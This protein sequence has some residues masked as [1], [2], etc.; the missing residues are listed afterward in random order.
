MEILFFTAGFLAGAAGIYF[1]VKFKFESKAW[2]AE[3][4]NKIFEERNTAL[5]SELNIERARILELN[6]S[7]SA[8]EADCKNLQGRLCEQKEE[9]EN[10]QQKFSA[11]FKNIANELLEEKSRKFT[12]Q[13]KTNIESILNPLN[14]K[15]KEFQKRVED[16]YDKESKQRFSL[17]K[18]IK[19]LFDLNQ[20]MAKEANNLTVALKGQTKT[21]GSWGEFILDSILEKSGLQKGREYQ[22][23]ET[24]TNEDGRRRQPDVIINLPENKCLIID[25]KVSLFAYES[26]CSSDNENDKSLYLKDHIASIRKHIRELSSKNYQ[27]LYQINTLDF[28][29]LFMPIEPAFSLAV[30]N[31]LNIFNE[32]FERNIV[33]VSPSTLLA[34]LRTIA[35]IWRQEYQNRNAL[36]IARQSG[37]LYDKFQ[38]MI[39]DLIELGKKMRAM[40]INYDEAM[41]KLIS[42]RGNLVSS[43]EKIKKLGAKATKSL[44]QSLLERVDEDDEEE[45]PEG[46]LFR[47]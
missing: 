24:F 11:E 42:G 30:Q 12:E 45:N 47:R 43:V 3:E 32:A 13:N 5:S 23:Q 18:E 28:V 14:E 27:S 7:H 10:L 39:S 38:G 4:R 16:T 1:I 41:K 6:R 17:E 25:S 44:P 21:Q 19:I 40:E 31:D 37:A 8:M 9:L 15:L 22:V 46:D 2:K 36:E 29:L 35:S 26:Y 33:I 34:T 20:Q